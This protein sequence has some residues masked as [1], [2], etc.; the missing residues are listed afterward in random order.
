MA[1]TKSAHL[2]L[3]TTPCKEDEK[4]DFDK[5][6]AGGTNFSIIGMEGGQF[7]AW[8]DKL[9]KKW[10]TYSQEGQTL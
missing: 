6:Q 3:Q 10:L 9:V 7:L 1:S 8:R 4:K 5:L 2:S